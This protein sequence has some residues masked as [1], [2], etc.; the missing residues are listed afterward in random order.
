MV[1]RTVCLRLISQEFSL[2]LPSSTC[3][4]VCIH[5]AKVTYSYVK[6]SASFWGTR[7][8]PL[9]GRFD[10]VGLF[11]ATF[12]FVVGLFCLRVLFVVLRMLI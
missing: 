6:V 2:S 4:E 7:E 9:G 8:K 10:R 1:V 3:V 12:F 5:Q 11:Y